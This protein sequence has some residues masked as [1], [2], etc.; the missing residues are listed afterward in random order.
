MWKVIFDIQLPGF[1]VNSCVITHI[2]S[3]M[4]EDCFEIG[5]DITLRNRL[6]REREKNV[7]N[8]F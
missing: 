4:L 6:L 5:I 7:N 3:N 2:A 1:T 8:G